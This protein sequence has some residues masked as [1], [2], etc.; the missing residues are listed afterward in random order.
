MEKQ[1]DV[2]DLSK[3]I[4]IAKEKRN[5]LAILLLIPLIISIVATFL[6]PKTYQS[7]ALLRVENKDNYTIQTENEN[8]TSQ[9]ININN[10]SSS[11][12]YIELLKSNAVLEPVSEELNISNVGN[13]VSATNLK[14]TNLISIVTYGKT[15]EEAQ[16][17]SKSVI[18]N[19]YNVI[20]QLDKNADTTGSELN[21]AYFQVID[22][23]SLSNI[24]SPAK[25]NKKLVISIG[26][27]VG[28]LL[29]SIYL[30]IIYMKKNSIKDCSQ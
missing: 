18:H 4:T 11:R 21:N 26:F 27:V 25:P 2:I 1:D 5:I 24:D 17:L 3:I 20:L 16:L 12:E 15:P 9:V 10:Y 19:F 14:E 22:A 6:L 8:N 23:P 28:L 30:S 29:I 13:M 7:T